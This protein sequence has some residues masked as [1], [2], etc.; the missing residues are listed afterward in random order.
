MHISGSNIH[1]NYCH[2]K[3][4]VTLLSYG[5]LWSKMLLPLLLFATS[6]NFLQAQNVSNS[7]QNQL[8]LGQTLRGQVLDADSKTALIGATVIVVGTTPLLATVTD[9][10]GKFKIESVPA[11]RLLLELSYLGYEPLLLPN[12]VHKSGKETV[13]QLE[14][15]ES[16]F[17]ME[18]VVV[19]AES[20]KGEA[21]NE[22][23]LI[24]TRSISAEETD[25]YAGGFNDPSRIATAF[26]GVATSNDG[27]NS[28]IV[29]GNA[30]KYMHWRLEGVEITNPTH[31]SDQ[32]ATSGGLSLLN[33]NLLA[34]SDFSTGAFAPEYGNALSGVYDVKLRAG[35]NE[36]YE[37]T[38]GFGILGTDFTFEGPFKKGYGGSF[39]L[40]YRYSTIT[41]IEQIG[42]VDIDGLLKFQDATAKLVFPTKKAG[43]Y[44]FFALAGKSSFALEDIKRDIWP[45]P[46]DNPS[47]ANTIEDYEKANSMINLGFNHSFPFSKNNYLK[48][49]FSYSQNG[50]DEV[51]FESEST[52][53]EKSLDYDSELKQTAFQAAISY[54]HKLNARNKVQ[55]GVR[56][57]LLGYNYDQ[58]WLQEKL[59]SRFVAAAFDETISTVSSYLSWKHRWNESLSFVAGLHN[60]NVLYNNKSSLE[61]RLAVHWKLHPKHSVQFGYG[62]HSSMESVHNYFAKVEDRSGQTNE[63]NKE[64]GLLRA[65]HYVLTYEN[66]ISRNLRAKV[67]FY[68]QDLYNIPVENSLTST[69]SS[70]NE[71]TDFNYVELVNEGTGKNYGVEFTLERFFSNHFYYTLNAS[72]FQS[73]YKTLDGIERSTAYDGDYIVNLLLG[74]AFENLGKKNN[75][76]L[77]LN[78]R[79]F[80]GGGKKQ[81]LLLRDEQGELAVDPEKDQYWDY[82]NIYQNKLEDV[83]SIVLSASYKVN[84]KK[85]THELFLTIDNISNTKGKLNEYYDGDSEDS[86]GYVRQFGIFPNLLYRVYF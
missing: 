26:A 54:H 13:L 67:D 3:E 44:S 10:D 53:G 81:L 66:R 60:M 83:Y 79:V 17:S 11:G 4:Y 52:D 45:T 38:L 31:F 85:A 77:T 9:L 25:R 49:S 69:Y 18:E 51:V 55:A 24:S 50:I 42:L 20:Q 35:N 74:R 62:N 29:R 43:L 80:A 73:T 47:T 58:S 36:K 68:Y 21:V 1:F 5:N 34:R 7:G 86:I 39:L 63:P 59:G 23:S 15:Q 40:N 12:I 84:R 57:A 19:K 22:M 64:L 65:Q 14:M 56:T 41:L 27:D 76:S 33:N 16:L 32:N 8:E 28:I 30:P 71:G 6:F 2:S 70:L 82:E 78:A 37:S 46:G 72:V 48:S 75:K 61:P